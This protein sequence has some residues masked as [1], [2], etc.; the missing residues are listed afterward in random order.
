MAERNIRVL[1]V[2]DSALMREIIRDRIAATPGLE[3]AGIAF[4]GKRALEI[5]DDVQPDVVTLDIEMPNL[6]GLATLD[7][8]LARQ[9]VPVIMVSSLTQAGADITLDALERGAV[10]Y[11]AKP[12]GSADV[13]E[14]IGAS[15]IQKIRTSAGI[16]VRRILEI[17]KE[18]KARAKSPRVSRPAAPEVL[19]VNALEL[20]DKCIAIGVSTGGPPALARLFESL[21]SPMPPIVVVQHMPADF[22]KAFAWRLNSISPLSIKEAASGD[23]LRPN[24]VLVAPGGRHVVLRQVDGRVKAI[25]RDGPPVSGH[26]PSVDV[27]MKSA[28]EIYRDRCLGVIMTGMGRDG[29]D[30]CRDIRS[31]GGCVFGQN[32]ASSDVY[33]MNKVAFVEGNVDRQFELDEAAGVL[34]TQVRRL[35][36]ASEVLASN[37]TG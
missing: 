24:H 28:A 16:D 19:G 21:K 12:T 14:A 9:A 1:V 4:D 15:L 5:L 8:I 3:V 7:A 31:A 35:R 33:G 22:T 18:R 34:T 26:R 6:D 11:V 32:E 2:D 37:G 30:G 10:D 27:M 36:G 13:R 25:L 23:L 17:R 29:A 20:A